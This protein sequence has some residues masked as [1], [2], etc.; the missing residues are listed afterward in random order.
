[1]GSHHPSSYRIQCKN[2]ESLLAL[3]YSVKKLWEIVER[4]PERTLGVAPQISRAIIETVAVSFQVGT[5]FTS[6]EAGRQLLKFKIGV[7]LMITL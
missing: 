7:V 6:K 2:V 5:G 3:Y 4:L 1:M